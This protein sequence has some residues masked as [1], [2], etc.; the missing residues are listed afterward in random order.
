L[1]AG[2]LIAVLLVSRLYWI[3]PEF[4][5]LAGHADA[6][7]PDTAVDPDDLP[8]AGLLIWAQPPPTSQAA[9][10][11]WT[12]D[13]S[14]PVRVVCYRSN[15]GGLHGSLLQRLREQVGWLAPTRLLDI[16]PG[17]TLPDA[18]PGAP[19]LA[20]W[21]LI[22][23]KATETVPVELNRAT[24]A[25]TTVSARDTRGT[26]VRIKPRTPSRATPGAAAGSGRGRGAA[27]PTRL[28]QRAL[29]TAALRPGAKQTQAHL[30]LPI[31]TRPGRDRH[32][33]NQHGPGTRRHP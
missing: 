9:A 29:E 32:Q 27:E 16:P 19:L 4:T 24:A 25:P 22:A 26:V 17:Q 8:A 13:A 6:Q 7:L 1:A 28:G 12:L 10:A 3:D 2:S 31:S 30:R 14:G 33:A 20:T 15:G 5:T 21:L 18:G 11:S 23:Q